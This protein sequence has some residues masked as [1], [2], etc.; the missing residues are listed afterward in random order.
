MSQQSQNSGKN[1]LENVTAVVVHFWQN[2]V[3]LFAFWWQ[4]EKRLLPSSTL[5]QDFLLFIRQKEVFSLCL[6]SV[7]I[8][9]TLLR[10]LIRY[11]NGIF[12][13]TLIPLQTS[14]QPSSKCIFKQTQ[15]MKVG[16]F[17]VLENMTIAHFLTD[18]CSKE[19][20]QFHYP[21]C[22]MML[23][24]RVKASSRFPRG[25]MAYAFGNDIRFRYRKIN[26][27]H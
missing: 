26:K 17:W 7:V 13:Q 21:K 14:L 12:G 25:Q 1:K 5:S 18:F 2:Q 16:L 20:H 4:S 23:F 24:N 19:R 27:R 22:F 11:R 6:P 9:T 3:S 8:L 15:V 10:S